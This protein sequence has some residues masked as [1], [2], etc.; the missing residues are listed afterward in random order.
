MAVNDDANLHATI[1]VQL[2]TDTSCLEF[3]TV[4]NQRESL[5]QVV[6][7]RSF[8]LLQKNVSVAGAVINLSTGQ[9]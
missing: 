3:H 9:I 4:S 6:L 2:N 8:P 5:A 7:I 1:R